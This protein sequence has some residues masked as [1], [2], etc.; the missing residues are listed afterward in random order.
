MLIFIQDIFILLAFLTVVYLT[1]YSTNI[2]YQMRSFKNNINKKYKPY[3][4]FR[5]YLLYLI[6]MMCFE[7][8]LS[9]VYLFQQH[10]VLPVL[11]ILFSIAHCLPF[12]LLWYKVK[13]TWKRL[14]DVLINRVLS[15]EN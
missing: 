13:S 5:K 11:D 4:Q 3:K 7:M 15:D 6:V 1:I 14:K 10:R 9:T 12:V 8:S 2:F